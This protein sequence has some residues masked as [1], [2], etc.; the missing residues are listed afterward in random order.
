M[1]AELE[2]LQEGSKRTQLTPWPAE[3]PLDLPLEGEAAQQVSEPLAVEIE[4]LGVRH[5][6]YFCTKAD[7]GADQSLGAKP[8]ALGV[9][10]LQRTTRTAAPH[11]KSF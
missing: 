9:V 11:V 6:F 1:L 3:G 5:S 4:C 8:A 2:L 7:P 10:E